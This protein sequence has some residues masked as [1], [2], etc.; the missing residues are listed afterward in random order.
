MDRPGNI[1][2]FL[3]IGGPLADFC[4]LVLGPPGGGPEVAGVEYFCNPD[5]VVVV[6]TESTYTAT[7]LPYLVWETSVTPDRLEVANEY[8]GAGLKPFVHDPP[9]ALRVKLLHRLTSGQGRIRVDVELRNDSGQ[10]AEITFIYQDAAYMWLP[11]RSQQQVD[12]AARVGGQALTGR[13]WFG[14][15]Q[16]GDWVATAHARQGVV[17][18]LWSASADAYLGVIPEY[19]LFGYHVMDVRST[20]SLGLARVSQTPR[21]AKQLIAELSRWNGQAV[22]PQD[23]KNRILAVVF[24]RVAPGATVRTGY[25]QWGFVSP[26]PVHD[27]SLTAAIEAHVNRFQAAAG[28]GPVEDVRTPA[29]P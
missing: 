18:G 9:P 11:D 28:R 8:L 14:Q 15:G 21:S 24:P 22:Q 1:A 29:T 13:F 5:S 2:M 25:S 4:S 23:L 10:D 12:A 6:R 20:G 27:G 17:A 3:G 26:T 7:Y 16:A 19:A